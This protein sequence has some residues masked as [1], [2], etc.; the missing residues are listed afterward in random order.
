V[1]G[2]N[3]VNSTLQARRAYMNN[4]NLERSESG[5]EDGERWWWEIYEGG[6][7]SKRETGVQM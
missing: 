1:K 7:Y 6:R 2:L 5:S 4:S 3:I